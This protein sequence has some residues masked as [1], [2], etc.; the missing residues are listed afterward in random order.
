CTET[1]QDG[2]ENASL[3]PKQSQAYAVKYPQHDNHQGQTAQ[4]FLR[5]L[6][7]LMNDFSRMPFLIPWNELKYKIFDPR[8]K[9]K[10]QKQIYD[11]QYGIH[12][13]AESTA[14]KSCEHFSTLSA[15]TISLLL[16]NFFLL[17]R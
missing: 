16:N 15:P 10:E 13:H 2:K 6:R 7:R 1:A 14:D 4:V 17:L 9:I 5:Y 3:N 11:H 8:T 12:H